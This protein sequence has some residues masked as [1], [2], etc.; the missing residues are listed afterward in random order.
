MSI[1]IV[2]RPKDAPELREVQEKRRRED[3]GDKDVTAR[4]EGGLGTLNWN[5]IPEQKETE[6]SADPRSWFWN[7]LDESAEASVKKVE[8]Q[9]YK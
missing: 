3:K 7:G 6:R 1:M 5:Q 9:F 2:L 4:W 8:Y